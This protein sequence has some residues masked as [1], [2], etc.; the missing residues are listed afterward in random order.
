[1]KYTTSKPEDMPNEEY[2]AD[3]SQ[4]AE[5]LR[6]GFLARGAEIEVLESRA[7]RH[8]SVRQ[9]L[10]TRLSG[11]RL[12]KAWYRAAFGFTLGVLI[13]RLFT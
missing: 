1:M 12:H 9:A 6:G 10:Y 2:W 13:V 3:K 11:E 8:R 7:R 4:D 5:W